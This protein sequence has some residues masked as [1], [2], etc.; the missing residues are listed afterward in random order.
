MKV[1]YLGAG[2]FW[3]IE[4]VYQKVKGVEEVIP[5]YM[6]GSVDNPSYEAVATGATGHAEVV[7]IVYDDTVITMEDILNIFF[8]T[9][10]AS[11]PNHVGS[12][13][14]SQYRSVIFY[15]EDSDG[16][17]TDQE[18]GMDIAPIQRSIERMQNA[19][20]E[21]V[22]VGT[23][24]MSAVQFYPAEESHYRFYEQNPDSPYAQTVITPKLKEVKDRF[25][26]LFL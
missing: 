8:A 20:P 25:L 2:G 7:K 5:G 22:T 15:T 14:G 26:N 9:H 23:R 16:E 12:G 6:G 1:I 18:N 10:D 21:G 13:I 17:A 11:A 19:F 3:T 24:V 4:A